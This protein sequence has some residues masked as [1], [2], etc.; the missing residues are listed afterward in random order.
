[1]L[2]YS[3]TQECTSPAGTLDGARVGICS[4][5]VGYRSRDKQRQQGIHRFPHGFLLAPHDGIMLSSDCPALR[6]WSIVR[7]TRTARAKIG[8]VTSTRAL[9]CSSW[10]GL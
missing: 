10:A 9:A 4:Q 7:S 8:C 2:C 1:M 5:V 3:V 6:V